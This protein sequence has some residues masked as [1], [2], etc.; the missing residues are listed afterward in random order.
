MLR[1]LQLRQNGARGPEGSDRQ[2]NGGGTL[3]I[4]AAPGIT[5][6]AGAGS[7]R[8]EMVAARRR[9]VPGV[10]T[11]PI[12]NGTAA[13]P[14]SQSA[15]IGN[16]LRQARR[17]RIWSIK[18][19]GRVILLA[20]P[21]FSNFTTAEVKPT[22]SS[23]SCRYQKAASPQLRA[24]VCLLATLTLVTSSPK[25]TTPGTLIVTV[26]SDLDPLRGATRR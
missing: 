8:A 9:G 14:A 18:K 3:K 24:C 6:G 21:D 13:G 4:S 17:C 7:G 15:S 11:R 5:S 2:R 23:W 12:V 22:M 10:P 26:L 19:G 16:L 25:V 1:G 20:R